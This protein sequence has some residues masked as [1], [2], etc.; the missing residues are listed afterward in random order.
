MYKYSV[1]GKQY[2]SNSVRPNSMSW[3]SSAIDAM[4][5]VALYPRNSTT[6]VYYNENNP[7]ESYLD[8]NINS[9][10]LIISVVIILIGLMVILFGESDY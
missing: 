10:G 1:N 7:S 8:T 9:L 3:S 4:S 6:P 2:T 5:V